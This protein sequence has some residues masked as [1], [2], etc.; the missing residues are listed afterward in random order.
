MVNTVNKDEA[1]LE[2]IGGIV[3]ALKYGGL[4][5]LED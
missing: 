4:K 5:I 1:A 2:Q 3:N